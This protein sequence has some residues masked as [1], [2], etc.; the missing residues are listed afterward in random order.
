MRHTVMNFNM[1]MLCMDARMEVVISGHQSSQKQWLVRCGKY[2]NYEFRERMDRPSTSRDRGE[3][4]V[5][6]GHCK[7][8]ICFGFV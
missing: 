1:C 3:I 5:K 2:F 8:D 6:G 4:G 7:L